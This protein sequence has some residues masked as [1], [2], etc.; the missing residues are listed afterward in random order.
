M[1][2]TL[3]DAFHPAVALETPGF[4]LGDDLDW[5]GRLRGHRAT[6][7][8]VLHAARILEALAGR[9]LEL[10]GLTGGQREAPTVYHTLSQLQDYGHLSRDVYLLL[11][12]LR[13]LG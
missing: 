4:A 11:D 5:L 3:R 10:T 12:R 9:A 2:S 7:A 6:V 8:A 13:D 1:S